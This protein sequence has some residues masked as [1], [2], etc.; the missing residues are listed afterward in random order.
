MT[1]L[2]SRVTPLLFAIL[3]SCLFGLM[4]ALSERQLARWMTSN[5]TQEEYA[6]KAKDLQDAVLRVVYG[7]LS[8][9]ATDFKGD[10]FKKVKDNSRILDKYMK[11]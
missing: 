7:I 3:L 11:Q 10:H 5:H 9:A 4:S 8:P 6:C 2:Q 1:L